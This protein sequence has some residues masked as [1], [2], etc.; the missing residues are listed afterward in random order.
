MILL[1]SSGL[2]S[3]DLYLHKYDIWIQSHNFFFGDVVAKR[4]TFKTTTSLICHILFERMI[5]LVITYEAGDVF[6]FFL[7]RIILSPPNWQGESRHL[8]HALCLLL[9][10]RGRDGLQLI[11]YHLNFIIFLPYDWELRLLL[12]E[13]RVV[14]VVDV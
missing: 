4:Y 3:G 13:L 1:R 5:K 14:V 2:C 8:L 10:P 12:D 11:D 9:Y 6:A 7:L